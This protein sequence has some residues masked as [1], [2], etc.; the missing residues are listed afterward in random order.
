[1][2]DIDTSSE[3]VIILL[4]TTGA[5]KSYFLN[6]LLDDS[7]KEGHSLHSE[8]NKCQAVQILLSE[9]ENEERRSITVVDTPGF[10]D[11]LRPHGEVMAE[12]TTFLAAQYALGLPLR[13]ILYLHRI[14]DIRMTGS[15]LGY[16]RMFKSL[17]GEEAL[18]NVIIVTTM[19]N[20]LRREDIGPAYRREQ[21]LLDNFWGP[22]VDKGSYVAQFDGT[23]ESAY[24]LIFQLAGK[25]SVVLD[26]QKQIVDKDQSVLETPA[27]TDLVRQLEKDKEAYRIRA[28]LVEAQLKREQGSEMPDKDAIFQLKAEQA[29][30]KRML[31]VMDESI[32]CMKVRPGGPTR[33]RIKQAA[34]DQGQKAVETLT[35]ITQVTLSFALRGFGRRGV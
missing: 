9:D 31:R 11:T 25:E 33:E 5:G 21:E 22:L 18:Q 15:S 12:I 17:V 29:Q 3:G 2:D 34:K 8:T 19:W 30:V 23:S 28:D 1:M 26:I 13:G 14:T 27:G 35:A 24:A 6:R 4:G 20:K 32:E 10:D 16:L 7:V